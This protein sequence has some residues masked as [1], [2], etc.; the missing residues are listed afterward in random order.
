MTSKPVLNL[1]RSEAKYTTE[2]NDARLIG[3][4]CGRGLSFAHTVYSMFQRLRAGRC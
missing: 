2:Y 3:S 1:D 4:A